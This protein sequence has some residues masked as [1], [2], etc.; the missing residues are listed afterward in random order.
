MAIN[1]PACCAE[2]MVSRDRVLG[3]PLKFYRNALGVLRV[4]CHQF[5]ARPSAEQSNGHCIASAHSFKLGPLT[6]SPNAKV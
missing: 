1:A 4:R 6:G 2:F 3:R 5:R